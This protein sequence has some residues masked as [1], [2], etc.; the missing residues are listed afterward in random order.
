MRAEKHVPFPASNRSLLSVFAQCMCISNVAAEFFYGSRTMQI[1]ISPAKKMNVDTDSLPHSNM[2][3]FLPEAQQLLAKLQSLDESARK[4]LWRCSDNLAERNNSRLHSTALDKQLT[5]AILSYEGIQ[6]Q[7]MAPGVL[8][9][10]QL[11]YLEAHLW[12]VSGFYGLLRPFD[13]VVPYRLEMQAKLQVN[14]YPNLYAFWGE[15]LAK[16]IEAQASWVLNLASREY[17]RAVMP[18]LS[19]GIKCITCSF[20][21]YKEDKVIEKGTL[22][23]MARG[24]MVRWLAENN[25]TKPSDLPDFHRLNYRFSAALSTREHLVF[26]KGD[27]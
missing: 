6:Y 17:S 22:C 26:I 11:Q 23:K 16:T 2:P 19:P 4:K 7:Y 20:G 27:N 21:E 12:I 24:E 1:I 14:E 15:K 18:H 25:I 3:R 9:A 8:E 10:S 5:P 13:G